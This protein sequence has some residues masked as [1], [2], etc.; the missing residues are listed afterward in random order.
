MNKSRNLKYGSLYN[1][2]TFTFRCYHN[3]QHSQWCEK[4]LQKVPNQK[5]TKLPKICS[6]FFFSD[7]FKIVWLFYDSLCTKP[8]NFEISQGAW[9][10]SLKNYGFICNAI[11]F[12]CTQLMTRNQYSR[13]LN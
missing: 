8:H 13:S 10:Q 6:Y 3:Q 12:T 7:G 5:V 4:A 2:V 11:F 1:N 9:K